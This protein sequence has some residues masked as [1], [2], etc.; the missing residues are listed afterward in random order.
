MLLQASELPASELKV[1]ARHPDNSLQLV[2]IIGSSTD[3]V[4]VSRSKNAMADHMAQA[5]CSRPRT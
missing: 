1:S 2:P 5:S 3:Y 4:L